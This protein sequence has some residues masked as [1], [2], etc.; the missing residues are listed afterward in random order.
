MLNDS[1]NGSVYRAIAGS[2]TSG[3]IEFDRRRVDFR[4]S[5]LAEW[6]VTK[7]LQKPLEVGPFAA[8]LHVR[9]CG[10]RERRLAPLGK[11]TTLDLS[12]DGFDDLEGKRSLASASASV[13]GS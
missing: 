7:V 6:L 2:R 8:A 11:L 1:R 12:L 5:D 3:G 13:N 9:G 10:A 4:L